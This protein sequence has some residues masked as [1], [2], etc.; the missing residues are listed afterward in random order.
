MYGIMTK[1]NVQSNR[2]YL[3]KL[4]KFHGA[5]KKFIKKG[6]ENTFY[7]FFAELLHDTI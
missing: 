7:V 5:A 3:T 4:T 6:K 2:T 1:L